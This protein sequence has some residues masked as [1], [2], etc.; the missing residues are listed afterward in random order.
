MPGAP[1]PGLVVSAT[2]ASG[3]RRPRAAADPE[4][5]LRRPPGLRTPLGVRPTVRDRHVRRGAAASRV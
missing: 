3:R 4:A 1:D 5:A 2:L